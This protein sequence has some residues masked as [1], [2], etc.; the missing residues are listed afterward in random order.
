MNSCS[1]Y[2]FA[3]D[4][5]DVKRYRMNENNPQRS[6]DSTAAK[7][8]Y[9]MD[10]L[11]C[12][13]RVGSTKYYQ[14]DL[15][16]VPEPD[17]TYYYVGY[18]NDYKTGAESMGSNGA[19]SNFTQIRELP[20]FGL[21]DTL[22]APAGAIGRMVADTT[23]AVN[24]LNVAFKPAG[25]FLQVTTP[26]GFTN[27]QMRPNADSTIWTCEEMWHITSAYT[28]LQIRAKIYSGS[29][30][31][32]DDEGI[33]IP[34]WSVN[35]YGTQVPLASNRND[36]VEGGMDGWAR[37]YTNRSEQNGYMEFILANPRYHIH[38]DNN[39]LLGIQVPDQYPGDGA[40]TVTVE[41]SRLVNGFNF[42]GWNTKA[43]G[44][45]TT[46]QPN[47][48]VDFTS[49]PDGALVNDS[50]LTLYAQGSYTGTYHVAFSF[51]HSNGK[52]YF[53]TQPIGDIRYARARP[54]GDW[55]DTYQGMSDPYNTEPNYISTYKLIG[56][57]DPC[58]ECNSGEYLLDPRRE[59]RYGAKDSLLYYSNFAPTNDEYLGLYYENPATPFKDPV[60]IVANSSW[61]GIFT[62]TAG[63]PD[64]S[65]ADVQN[66][67]L[68]SE[69]YLDGFPSAIAR[70]TRTSVDS[71]FV[72]YNESLNQFDG[73]R[74]EGE[75]TTFQISRVRVADEHYVVLPDT[76]KTWSD[77]IEFAYHSGEQSREQ[78]WT[79]MI[80]KQLLAVTKTGN[81]TVYFHP[82]PDHI[83]QD[84]NNLYLDK[85][86]RVSQVF[87]FI[88]D[89]RVST[90]VA[91]ENRATHET[92]SYHWHNDIVSGLNSPIDVKDGEGNYIDIVDTFR[93]TM[94]HGGISKIKQYYGRWKTGA[95]GL[96]VNGDGSVRTRDVIVRTKT[97]HYGE[98]ITHLELKPEFKTYI[99]NPL[100]GNSQ[101]INFTLAHVTAHR[102]V[103]VNG[104]PIG[105]EEIID[106]ED[107]TKSLA[108][109]PGACTFSSA[110]SSST[111][112]NISEAVNQ[113]I[114]L[115]TKA[116]NKE[117]DNHDTLIISMNVTYGGK[118]YLVTARVP[119][120]QTSLESDELI[121]SVESGK[122][123]Y[124]IMA[125]TD[126]L[127]FR[128]YALKDGTL[129]KEGTSNTALIK[130]SKDPAN[131]DKQYIT[132][133][134]FS[135]PPSGSANQLALKT[136]YEVNRYFHID[137]GENKPEVHASDS[138]LLTFHYVDVLTNDNANEEELVK[139]QYGA[140]KWL[141]FTLTGGEGAKLVLVEDEKDASV[142]SWSYL[143]QEYSLL[144]NG[145]YPDR[146]TVI[147]GYN[148]DMSVT[149]Q[150]PYKA[151]KEYSM[152]VGSSVINC[153]REQETDMSNLTSS[154]GE[155]KTNQTFSIIRDARTFDSGSTPSPATSGI[156]QTANTVS[157]SG[158]SP[159]NVTIGGK[160]VNI[161]DTLLV[162][163]SLREGA[164]AYRF[165]GDWSKFRS[166]SDAELKIP[167]IRKTYHE[168]NYDS[169]I[170]VVAGD[171]YNH[172]FPNEIDPLHPESFTF[173]LGTVDRTGRHVLDVAN[174]TMEVL[175]KDETDVS[176]SMD[177]R[178]A[179]MAEVLL[180]DDYGNTP[181]WCRI[182][183]KTA[184]SITVECTQSGIRTPRMAYIR[185]F[186]IV[187]ISEK[188]YV[189][190]EQLTV[191]QP[192]YF[193]YANNQHLVHS[194]GA[195]GDPLR[196]DGMQQVHENK[197]I[198]YYYPKQDVELPIRDSHFFGWWRWFREGAGE[199]GDSDIPEASWRIQPRNTG[200]GKSGSYNFP[201][202]IIGDSVDDGAGGKKLVTMGRYTVF[203]YKAADYNDNKK[204][205]PVKVARVAPP[206]TT[207]GVAEASKPT[208]TYAAELSNYYDNLP[209]SLRYKN[210]VDTA[211][212]DTM[213]AIP[214]PTLSLREIFELHPWTEMADTLDHY[215]T[216]IPDGEEE[217]INKVFPLAN[218][219]Y[220]E[221]HVM[222]APTGNE[223]LL[224][225][226]QRYIY[227]HLQTTKQSES[228][229]GYYMRDDNWNA[230]GWD[231]VRKDTMIW[232][233]GWDATCQWYTYN[234]KTQKYSVCNHSKTV[235][236][237]FL[238]VPAKQNITNGQEFDTVYYCLRARS[239]SS[240]HAGTV[241]D[242]DDEEPADGAYMFNICRYKLIYHKPGKYGPLA[243]TQDKAGNTKALITNDDI[244]QHYEVLERLNFDY[245]RP[246]PEYT[247]YPHPLPWADA[248]YGYTYP[249]T[250]DLP[251]NRLHAHSDFPNHG[252]YGLINRIPT[253][254][255]WGDGVTSYW[256]PM[257]QHGGASNGYMIYC[258]G[259]SSSGQVAALSLETHLCSGQKMF[260]SGYVCNP[261][262]QTGK[263]DP[264]FTFA[265]Q[266]SVNG[267][268][269]DDIT[270]YTTGGI[271]P[272]SQWSQIYFPIV[273]DENIDYKQFRVRIYNVSS[274]WDGNDFIIDDMCIFATKPPLIA[275]Q[276]NTACKEK[277]DEELPSHVILRVDYQ[278]IIGEGYNDTT[279]CYTLKSVNKDR[280]VTFVEMIDGYLDQDQQ[281][282]TIYG[283]LYIPSKTYEPT[284]P[285]SIFVNMNE[286]I[287]TFT[288]SNGAFK[289]GYIYEILEGDIRPV[290]YVVH[291]AYVNAVD[292]FTVHMSGNY[293]D[294][295]NSLCGMTS[296]LKVSNQMVLELNGE[297]QPTT[298]SLDL[299]ANS[300]YDIGL[301]VKG[302]LY[303]DS[304]APINLNGTCANDW[305][306]YG[307]TA[308]LTGSPKRRYGYKYSD[309]VK[310][311]KDILRCDPP[312]TENANQFAP[313]L[314][315]VSRN[316]MQRIKDAQSVAL[317]TTAHPYDI[318]A[319]L[320]NKG[321]LT[322]YKPTL[323]ANVYA[324]DSVQYVIFPIL[325]TGTDTKQHSSVEVCPLPLLIKLKPQSG[326]AI[327]LIVG[328]LNRDSSEMRLPVVV[329]ADMNMANQQITLRVDSIMPNIGISTVEL[330][331]TDDPDFQEGF[332]KLAL[333]PD[334]DY[335][336]S[337][338][339][340]KGNY[341]TLQ[342]A[343]SNNYTMKQGYNY[344]FAIDLQT[345]LGKD[346]L[347]G[348]CKVGTVPFTLAVV[349]D[350][351]RWDPQDETSTQW[352]RHGNWMGIDEHNQPMHATA[353]FAPLA[354]T[355][356]IIPAMTDGKPYPE[357][358]D[359]TAPA[360]YDS[361]KQAG[362]QYNQCNVIRFLPGAAIGQQQYLND[363]T[364]V[365]VDM[366]FPNK[367]WAFRSAPIKGMISGDLYMSE[368]DLSGE[369]PLWEVGEFDASGRSYKTGNASFWVSAYNTETK[370]VNLTGEDS[371][372]T[373]SADWSRVTN[374][375][376]LPFKEGKGMAIYARGREGLETPVVRLPKNDDTYYFYGTYGERIDDKYVGHLR[377]KRN[378]L[379]SPGVA[380]ELIYHPDGAYAEYTLTNGEE[381]T[382]FVFG[383]P[384]MAYIDIWGFIADNC[385][386]ER[387]DF[388]DESPSG[389]SVYTSISKSAA[390]ATTDRIT[391]PRRY[392]PPMRAIVLKSTSGTSLSLRLYTNRVIT[393][394]SQVM[395]W[396]PCGSRGGDQGLAQAPQRNTV[397]QG[398]MTVTAKNPCSPRCTSRLLIGQG[399]H[400]AI[401]DG[402]DAVLTTINIDNYSNTNAPATPF[403]IYAAEGSYGLSIDL[404]NEVV[405]IPVS[406]FISDLPYEPVTNLWFTGV[407][408]IDGQLV[409]YDEWTNT[410]RR[411]ID[412]ICL[413]IETPEQSHQKRY[414]IRRM[415]YVPDEPE[416]PI[417][418]G[419]EFF[420]TDEN[421]Q[422]IK[423][424][425]DDQVLIIRNG[426]VYTMFGQKVR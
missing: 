254:D 367:K 266:G 171:A 286:L 168:A 77:T 33:A 30:Y 321:F 302:S 209:M 13:S 265:V 65:V 295:L 149:I 357:L 228:L 241:G 243:E 191:S 15:M 170:C 183:G 426:H 88:P 96:K 330:R 94:S 156:S 74:T 3:T 217:L 253:V 219:K 105:E 137:D 147:F 159:R 136:K 364:D 256:R 311:V 413:D 84:P 49:L 71:S 24:N 200:S 127:K 138:S 319:D 315:A 255:H 300:T 259:M 296:H 230:P 376:D 8:I 301:R 408:N 268:D 246:G 279:V 250:P 218:E 187:I 135:Y 52:R 402:E 56:G 63:W 157:T 368:A 139:L 144:N 403:N 392:L 377:D 303:L 64:Y 381:D 61:A 154:G 45:G 273:F 322:L 227:E 361:V 420:D 167:L 90:A 7:K 131:S 239:K 214:E 21:A 12:M 260:F 67:K 108:L 318:L 261:S 158:D 252:E 232:C 22:K 345:I 211:M 69:D 27:V 72:K 98:T 314:A 397:R 198:L 124:Y 269:W 389:A 194:P 358:P 298:E 79:S 41:K 244:E 333:V 143:N 10:R 123:R 348:G 129:Y 224:S 309:I 394:T 258:D 163:L 82:D 35:I 92:T 85:N 70:H 44:S 66:T 353:R 117:V 338:Y 193:Q 418:T 371:T 275:Y 414:Y 369:T 317:D 4:E 401:R 341:I 150:A 1:S 202:R 281:N 165:K 81:D 162:T 340:I 128:Q 257:E 160:Y 110:G 313:T 251:H 179:A 417:T 404:R 216:E 297:E 237:D 206:L 5:Q 422:A 285:D 188:M 347:D 366:A 140:D 78:V 192:S 362:F 142:F 132:P 125:G 339:Y 182:S 283:R 277:A 290:K 212:M 327:P 164:P 151:Y 412:G 107:I 59:W 37:I 305:L 213:T 240:P 62:S 23:S 388:M 334:L 46:Y 39:G 360:T 289:E 177:L 40:T 225:T 32:P 103:D 325:G 235:S 293:K 26:V 58:V 93:I 272:S 233:G 264:N 263:A 352:N 276:A 280:V 331:T 36:S 31:S 121:W 14:T 324:G 415:G 291:S 399:Y 409:L 351:L 344:T 205:P 292:T 104:N 112:F 86:F 204:N 169:L 329:L 152:L 223:L 282:D 383:N 395:P 201:F 375:I 190:T 178:S 299:C 114:T 172:T 9:T 236:D 306:L 109:G 146:D 249:E 95:R 57:P 106:S 220:M 197:R 185:I 384:T 405:N 118:E 51:E 316:E 166:V 115:A 400:N 148:T 226:E 343:S 304:V 53:L 19:K 161:V 133:W 34:G 101:V 100:E 354:T 407:N 130:G 274:D 342:P 278:G 76:T 312:G 215:K 382:V 262:S 97:Y 288:V 173:N 119:L 87:E 73:V 89:S 287:D 80:G 242:P 387:F 175:D 99:F 390:L 234:P 180:L 207:F 199:I 373:A 359:L 145:A 267:T 196:A 323:T 365:V 410:E 396:I 349:P 398:I 270:S 231:A 221:D 6:S 372:R 113:H 391:E 17:S 75:A 335:P 308:D 425:K 406:F 20:I 320:V 271:K 332:H 18:N 350:Y 423:I 189:V 11:T 181:T 222:M 29:E 370:H 336:Q 134:Q 356:V 419:M 379:A 328:G 307:D 122:K 203:H 248:S 60:T 310:V 38:Y 120:V 50:I 48:V 102:L 126:G 42:T 83:I 195:S 208:V 25:Y 380:G 68:K 28:A 184:T 43:D 386:V 424:I 421:E 416:T 294:M 411:I 47:N 153:C 374:A 54:V 155:W 337:E 111:Y 174:M 55:T 91:E 176:G 238:K 116:V 346:T 2:F 363:Q 245:N 210:Q 229:L 141:Q 385:L 355:A 247:I 284:N 16:R 326:S 393:E 186:Y 378:E